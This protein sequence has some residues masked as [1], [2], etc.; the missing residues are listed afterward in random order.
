MLTTTGV[1]V[2]K[3]RCGSLRSRVMYG[4]Q[5]SAG[6]KTCSEPTHI[7]P[8]GASGPR[9]CG[10]S[11]RLKHTPHLV[12]LSHY[13]LY[14]LPHYI[15]EARRR[16][17]K[18][19][20]CFLERTEDPPSCLRGPLCTQRSDLRLFAELASL[21]V[22]SR[23]MTSGPASAAFESGVRSMQT[24]HKTT[25][26]LRAKVVVVGD[27]CVGKTSVVQMFKSG[28]HDYPKNYIMVST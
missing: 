6:T 5:T 16:R 1:E 12:L 7:Y 20:G 3:G 10:A 18:S 23:S 11:H 26:M 19:C 24:S 21:L 22:M 13:T 8:H 25:L 15:N 2:A 28:G 17:S 4:N 9:K 14:Q 27:A